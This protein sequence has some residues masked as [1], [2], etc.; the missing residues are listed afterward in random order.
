[1]AKTI[2]LGNKDSFTLAKTIGATLIEVRDLYDND[3]GAI[4]DFVVEKLQQ[5]FD[6]LLIDADNFTRREVAL[7]IGMYMRLSFIELKK[8]ALNPIIIV[9][10]KRIKSFMN[11]KTYSQLLLT[12]KVYFQ[13]RTEIL[14][15]A[16]S[17]IDINRYKADFL[18][19]IFIPSRASEGRHS[20]A[21]QWGASVLDRVMNNGE[22]SD[23]PIFHTASKSLYFKYILAQ[24]KDI[25][26]FF[27]N[28]NTTKLSFGSLSPIDAKGK[29]ILLID[30]EAEKG[31]E[32]V[33]KEMIVT[34]DGD[35]NVIS[36]RLKDYGDF[37][38]EERNHIEKNEYDL[39]F[40]DLRMNGVSEEN[41]MNPENFS[42][43]KILKSIKEL[44]KG[45]QVIMLT[46]SNKAWNMK[47]LLD[48]GADGYYI[49]ESPEYTFPPNY[50]FS[51]ASELQKCIDRCLKNSYLIK[52]FKKIKQIKELIM[53]SN[54]FDDRTDEILG[55][56]DVAYDLLAKSDSNTEYKSYA[57]LQL[58]LTVEDYVKHPSIFDE[59]D[60]G[61]YLYGP[62][63]RYRILKD[64]ENKGKNKSYNSVITMKNGTG[65]FM[66]GKGKYECRYIETNFLVSSMLIFKFSEINSASHQWTKIYKVRNDAAHPKDAIITQNDFHR[67]LD[68]MIY[69]F[70][71]Q[72]ENWRNPNQAFQDMSENEQLERLKAKFNSK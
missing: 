33:L 12:K 65:H 24:T 49:K 20:L 50:S 69:F 15:N 52:V 67:I 51:N 68:F 58:F 55:S 19:Y 57:Y 11:I 37:T 2:L 1:M 40:L 63:S 64:K 59:T 22:Q 5:D 35:F 60:S 53:E 39:V 46:A 16:V 26:G 30:D 45:T 41:I 4:H 25:E 29:R 72:N 14:I 9:S 34:N 44:N 54:C 3:N 32:Y 56:I 10:D 70:N 31:W 7:A 23:N 48:A 36:H 18:D 13:S 43:M 61:L 28:K 71:P 66:L 17:P 27:S 62:T 38:E 47:A 6:V 21:N 8:N 42:G